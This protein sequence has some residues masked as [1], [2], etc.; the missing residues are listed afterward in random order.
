V[1]IFHQALGDTRWLT[2]CDGLASVCHQRLMPCRQGGR[3]P[4]LE[5]LRNTPEVDSVLREKKWCGL[6]RCMES[7]YKYGM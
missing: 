1:E 2:C 3:I 7:D 6:T 4:I 5:I